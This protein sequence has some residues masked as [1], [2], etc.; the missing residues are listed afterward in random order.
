M[1]HTDNL[2][3]IRPETP[4]EDA[5]QEADNKSRLDNLQKKRRLVHE[6]ANNPGWALFVEELR[7][8]RR[9]LFAILERSTDPTSLAKVAGTLLAVE[10]FIDWPAYVASEL[11]AQA[12][13]IDKP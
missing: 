8:E 11:D 5:K 7:E 4:N 3:K 9:K 10:S 1:K 12:K 13:D 2:L 6:L